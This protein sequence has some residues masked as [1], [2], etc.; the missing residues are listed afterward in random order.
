MLGPMREIVATLTTGA[1]LASV[2]SAAADTRPA[3]GPAPPRYRESPGFTFEAGLGFGSFR[4]NSTIFP[5]GARM[6]LAGLDL[7]AGWFVTRRLAITA[8][9]AGVHHR[10]QGDTLSTT[11][12]GP[13]AQLWLA[14]YAWVGAGAGLGVVF[15]VGHE[16]GVALDARAGLVFNPGA[17]HSVNVSI[18]F[19]PAF[20]YDTV[21]TGLSL[22]AGY[23]FM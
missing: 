18:E 14:P 9:I 12:V 19:S 11:F 16:L 5:R 21:F 6:S 8:R 10:T 22:L 17:A 15:D 2:A 13:S 20:A 3:R 7:G 4:G 1:L 23:Q